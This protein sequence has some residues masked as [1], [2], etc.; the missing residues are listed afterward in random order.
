MLLEHVRRHHIPMLYLNLVGGND[1][2]IFDGNS[3]VIADTA[4]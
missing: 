4:T 2:L 3:L 1:D